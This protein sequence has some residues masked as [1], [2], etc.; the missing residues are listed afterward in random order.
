MKKRIIC[1]LL[2]TA[3]LIT[4]FPT[5]SFAGQSI[6]YEAE[7]TPFSV[8][9]SKGVTAHKSG[10]SAWAYTLKLTGA[11][12]VSGDL[13][14]FRSGGMGGTV[15]FTP[16]VEKAGEYSLVWA[17]RP[18][19][20][21]SSIVQVLVNGKEVGGEISL[22]NGD[23]VGGKP[24]NPQA[25]R[26]VT[27]GNAQF[28]EGVN[29]VS[30]KIVGYCVDEYNSALTVDY[31]TLGDPVD[32]SKLTFTEKPIVQGVATK[33]NS[34]PVQVKVPDGM[35]DA[36]LTEREAPETTDK[37][38]VHPL[39]DCYTRASE[40]T[41]TVDGVSVPI[42]G[43][44]GDYDYAAFDYDPLKGEIEVV[45][46][47]KAEPKE[48]KLSPMHLAPEYKIDGKS[49]KF[50]IS[51]NQYYAVKINSKFLIIAADE[52]EYKRPA[53]SGE[54]IFNITD[55]PYSVSTDMTD[56][57]RTDAIQKALD[58]ASAYGG[59]KGNKNGVVYVPKGVYSIGNLRIGS[60]TYLY[61]EGGAA[62]RITKDKSLLSID[63]CK[64]SMTT[65]DGKAGLDYTWWISTKFE[66][67]DAE[68]LGSYDIRIG[69]R[70]TVD[71][72]GKTF[73]NETSLGSNTIIP[74]AVSHMSVEGI[75]AREAVCWSVI[76]VR[77]NEM[78]FS[79]LK[80]LQSM[81]MG[82]NDCIDICESQNVRVSDCIGFSLDDPFST[83]CWPK[84]VGITVNWPGEPEYLDKVTFEGCVAYT[85][86]YGYKIGQGTDQDQYDVTFKDCT[87]LDGSIGFG[88]HCKSGNGTVYNAVFDGCT[89]EDL[90]G[91]NWEHSSWFVA[92]LHHNARGDANI[93]GITVKNI[94]VYKDGI[95]TKK[96]AVLGYDK[97]ST[98]E[99]VT[100]SNIVIDG[101]LA[102]SLDTLRPTFEKNEFATGITL[103]NSPDD[104]GNTDS[105]N[106][107][108]GNTD[109]GNTDNGNTNEGDKST[110][111]D[112]KGNNSAQGAVI[113][114]IVC[115][116][117][118]IGA[119]AV[120][121]I[122]KRKK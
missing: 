56:K 16:T 67:K 94:T 68:V 18:H 69:G 26:E 49:I 78:T 105:G 9:D 115:T 106:T 107:D 39:A 59:I 101:R 102:E 95:G 46:E 82:E 32:E 71:S 120:I 72:R 122:V 85:H 40:Y 37:I 10:D 50:T 88:I 34:T 117:L 57:Q 4:L 6:K 52:M 47:C 63:G 22:I 38:T 81:D 113:T 60:N 91:T 111:A 73:W 51:T 14:F 12:G 92:F 3:L 108:G 97:T 13:T 58:D 96:L 75:T 30:F 119:I 45:I 43:V 27:L 8:T 33:E 35:L 1:I 17:Y 55:A 29:T 87:T 90:H 118:V 24:N 86:C 5:L 99:N 41:L 15:D 53:V 104:E 64:T 70:G 109:N 2:C 62:L 54:G 7:S 23:I 76:S 103:D 66:E 83:K 112:K 80:L 61:L 77:S 121:L 36:P 110:D 42:T 65:P 19:D 28:V 44:D 48:V 114:V 116:V 98:V 11:I 25:V 93:R 21:S 79:R 20:K 89:V 84:K 74:I 100:F 31:F